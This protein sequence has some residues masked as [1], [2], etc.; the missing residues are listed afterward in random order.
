MWHDGATL[1]IGVSGGPDSMCLLD[2]M[3]RIARKEHLTIIV[4]HVNY[5][6]RNADS[7]ADEQ[8]VAK[9]AKR[10]GMHY[11]TLHVKKNHSTSENALRKTRYAFFEELRIR[12]HACATIVAHT[13]NDQAETILLHLLR[14]TG[15]RGLRGMTFMSSTHIARPLLEVSRAT[16]H[17]YLVAQDIPFRIDVTNT[18]LS[19]TRNRIRHHLIPYLARYYNPNIVAT[20]ART[21]HILEH[22]TTPPPFWHIDHASHTTTFSAKHFASLSLPEQRNALHTII[23]ALCDQS[24]HITKSHIDELRKI[25]SSTKTKTPRFTSKHLK[26]TKKNDTVY[27]VHTKK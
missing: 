2:I 1:I 27:L 17:D 4:A 23:T 3:M 26:L 24:P 5:H 19:Y 13:Q 21:A 10:Y 20:L 8:L 22:S 18:D 16:V 15:L 12:Y 25:I 6:L 9:T 7:N 11:H 14:G